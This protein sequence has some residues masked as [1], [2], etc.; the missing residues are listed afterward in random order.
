M[1]TYVYIVAK[2]QGLDLGLQFGSN[3]KPDPD[4]ARLATHCCIGP[5]SRLPVYMCVCVCVCGW[6]GARMG[7]WVVAVDSLISFSEKGSGR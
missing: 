3:R 5:Q 6:V 4:G 2:I 1:Y 7:G